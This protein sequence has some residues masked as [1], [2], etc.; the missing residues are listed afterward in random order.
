[1]RRIAWIASIAC[2]IAGVAMAEG[3]QTKAG[4]AD[5]HK[6]GKDAAEAVVMTA[7]G[8]IVDLGCYLGHGA[9]GPDHKGC[10]TKCI[11]GG[12]PMGLL[13]KDGT[14]YLLTMS[15]EDADPF[16]AAKELAAEKVKVTGPMH[17]KDGMKSIEVTAVE[18]VAKPAAKG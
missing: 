12:M 3:T 2:L 11:A 10:A 1:M 14:L 7:Q 18:A 17:E 9:K 16:N 5:A 13:A 8:E 15:H 6:D 4:A